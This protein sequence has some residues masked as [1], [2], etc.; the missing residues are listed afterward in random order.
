MKKYVIRRDLS[1]VF[2]PGVGRVVPGHVLV[3]DFEAYV[4]SLLEV[5]D[6]ATQAAEQVD[7]V[8]EKDMELFGVEVPDPPEDVK[9]K[10]KRTKEKHFKK[11]SKA[12]KFDPTD[13][14]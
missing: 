10:G 8:Y 2:L 11:R 14:D 12:T 7:A 4:P 6:E 1:M 3:G 13:I 5:K 9:I